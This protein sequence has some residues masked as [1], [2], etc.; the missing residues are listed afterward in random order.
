MISEYIHLLD[1]TVF[2]RITFVRISD[3]DF[4]ENKNIL[5]IKK[6]IAEFSDKISRI[7]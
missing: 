7:F 3:G 5:G 2:I 6:E 1:Y 4:E